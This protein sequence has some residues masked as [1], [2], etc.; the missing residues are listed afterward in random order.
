MSLVW[1]GGGCK[2]SSETPPEE[3][4]KKSKVKKSNVKFVQVLDTPANRTGKRKNRPEVVD[5][6]KVEL[7]STKR[8]VA[9]IEPAMM[10]EVSRRDV[11]I[12]RQQ[13]VPVGCTLSGRPCQEAGLDKP[14]ARF[15]FDPVHKQH[16]KRVSLLIVPLQE[17]TAKAQRARKE[18][19]LELPEAVRAKYVGRQDRANVLIGARIP[20][21]MVAEVIYSLAMAGVHDMRFIV[22]GPS[23]KGSLRALAP[24]AGRRVGPPPIDLKV[25]VGSE[26]YDLRWDES[27]A[28]EAGAEGAKQPPRVPA[29]DMNALEAQ[30][31]ALKKPFGSTKRI[32]ITAAAD[33]PWSEIA[34]VMAV[35]IAH[36]PEI[37]FALSG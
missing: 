13:V 15:Y 14:A 31:R 7:A 30:L 18:Q 8:K 28:E 25:I 1:F 19:T 2:Q 32:H 5:G 35:A 27:A 16:G 29:G 26:G 21:R 24:R 10:I 12:D 9:P 11:Q 34:R 20:F 17:A 6:S 3:E 23:G 33:T 22:L 36:F 4:V 37:V